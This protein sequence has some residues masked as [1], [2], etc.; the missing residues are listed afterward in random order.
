M[1]F[2]PAV[3]TGYWALAPQ[4]AILRRELWDCFPDV[5]RSAFGTIGDQDHSTRKSDHNPDQR[6]Y[7]RAID[8]PHIGSAAPQ[9]DFLA[10]FFRQVGATDSQRLASGGYVIWNRRIAS[11]STRWNWSTYMGESPHTAY[12]HLS[13]SRLPHFYGLVHPWNV[14]RALGK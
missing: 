10:E 1:I 4:I 7:V 11:A 6:R 2:L 3:P 8:I 5:P 13:V 12:L 9:I 14:R